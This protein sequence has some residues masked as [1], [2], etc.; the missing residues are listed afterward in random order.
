MKEFIPEN[1]RTR[2]L[3][4]S[5]ATAVGAQAYLLPTP[6]ASAIT[7]RCIAAMGNA[8]D[9]TLSL[10]YAD[11]TTGTNA[12]AFPENLPIWVNGVRQEANAVSHAVT[13]AIGNFIVDFCVDPAKIPAG[14]HIGVS[15]ANSNAANFLE[16]SMIEDTMFKPTAS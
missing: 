15:Y 8:A 3:L 14:K 6:G 4:A 1:F 9:L 2:V 7:V 5:Q 12:T 11:N 13:A 16:V 10:N